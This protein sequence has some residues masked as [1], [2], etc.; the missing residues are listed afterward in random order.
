QPSAPQWS[1]HYRNGRIAW[2]NVEVL[3]QEKPEL[4]SSRHASHYY[5]ARETDAAPLRIGTQWEKMIFYRGIGDFAIPI[6]PKFT[7][8]GRLRILNT[9]SDAIPLAILFEKHAGKV[10]YRVLK[11]I[12]ERIEVDPPELMGSMEQLREELVNQLVAF[13]LYRKEAAAMVET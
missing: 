7:S 6:E 11:R 3:P 13:E 1:D 2:D 9:G 8:E 12:A 5:A 10:G 4:P